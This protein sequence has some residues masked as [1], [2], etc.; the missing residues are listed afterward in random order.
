MVRIPH[1]D[2]LL[3]SADINGSIIEVDNFIG[4]ICEYGDDFSNLT[5]QQAVES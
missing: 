5:E 2:V 4:E 1:L 3:N